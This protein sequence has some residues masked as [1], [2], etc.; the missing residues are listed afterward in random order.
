MPL[1]RKIRTHDTLTI[2]REGEEPVVLQVR[3]VGE[4][5]L[6]ICIIAPDDV[7]VLHGSAGFIIADDPVAD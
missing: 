1:M 4:T 7:R 5:E 3:R 2:G 6:R